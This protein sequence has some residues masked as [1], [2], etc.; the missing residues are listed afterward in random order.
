MKQI[1][2]FS[3]NGLVLYSPLKRISSVLLILFSIAISLNSF[4]QTGSIKGIVT[5]QETGEAIPFANVLLFSDS[6]MQEGCITDYNGN[7]IIETSTPANYD[8]Q[9]SY[10]GYETILLTGIHI[11]NKEIQTHNFEMYSKAIMLE[12]FVVSDFHIGL[13]SNCW[14]TGCRGTSSSHC[15]FEN[16]NDEQSENTV[17]CILFIDCCRCKANIT[18]YEINASNEI[19]PGTNE[20]KEEIQLNV[21][22][23]PSNGFVYIESSAKAQ[24]NIK[25][26]FEEM[27]L[28]DISGKILQQIPTS[29]K[30]KI[31][32]DLYN[33]PNGMYILK[34]ANVDHW[35]YVKII[36]NH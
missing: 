16:V 18:Q 11:N 32:L 30:D 23:N 6:T 26:K 19:A 13:I 34:F 21:Y 1:S 27:Y 28:M 22:P 10:L 12:E 31:K 8:L 24:S 20:I 4:C 25:R 35:D 2:L 33:L 7:Y 36:L 15:D 9:I 3:R 5:D 17:E 14:T 29:D